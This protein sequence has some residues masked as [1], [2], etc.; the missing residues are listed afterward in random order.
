ML[1]PSLISTNAGEYGKRMFQTNKKINR[2]AC[3]EP[4]RSANLKK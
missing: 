2:W 1:H 4:S 3:T